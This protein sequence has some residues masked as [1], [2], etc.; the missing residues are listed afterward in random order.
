MKKIIVVVSALLMLTSVNAFAASHKK[1]KK[2]DMKAIVLAQFG[3]TVPS[4]LV[5]LQN[6]K[7]G[8]QKAF[9]RAEV[10]IAFTSNIIRKIWHKRRNDAAF[11]KQNPGISKH[12]AYVKT[13]LATIADLQDQGYRTIVVQPTHI[14][15]GEEYQ[16]LCS[17]VHALNTIKTIKAKWQPFDKLVIGRPLL[18]KPGV[19]HPFSEDIVTAAKAMAG[20]VAMARKNHAALVYMGHGNEHFSTGAYLQ[21]QH[22]M[23][24]MY[25]DV[26][27]V[28]GCVEGFPDFEL[29]AESLVHVG[30]RK[31]MIK[32]FMIVAGDHAHN[33]MAGPDKD[34]LKSILESKGIKVIPVLSGLGENNSVVAIYVQ[35]I[36]DAA[37]DNGIDL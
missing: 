36:K 25:P 16:D 23:R 32:P 6:L 19:E 35:H 22:V 20:D 26:F 33:D 24:E 15:A 18:G 9:P 1:A 4:A 30:A 5:A 34:S 17:L 11:W 10:R 7:A 8:V 21:L 13:P 29:M 2:A 27:T 12:F 28:V 14:Y 37:A 3:T 31:A